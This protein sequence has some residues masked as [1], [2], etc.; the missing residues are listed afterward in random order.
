MDAP[1]RPDEQVAAER[2]ARRATWRRRLLLWVLPLVVAALAVYFYGTA[3]RFV[4]T[5]NAYVQQDRVDV[6]PQVP[7]DVDRVL[8]GENTRVS[9]GQ[10]V[11]GL[12]DTLFR[13]AAAGAESRLAATRTEVAALQAAYREKAGE[14]ELAR[15][16]AE[17]A[18]RDFARQQQLADRKLVPASQLDTSHRSAE[19]AT[20]A[21]DVLRL[22][23]AQAAA[24]LGGDPSQPLDRYPSVRAAIAELDRARVDLEHT[25]IRA[26]QAGIVSH[27][28][29]VGNRLEM[30]RAAF[31]IVTDRHVWVEANFKETDLEWVRP[32]Q[33]VR[34]D[35]DTYAQHRWTGRVESIAQAT[36]AAFSLLP[37]QNAAGNWV[38]VVQRIPVR[39][40]LEPLAGDPPLRDGMSSTV[41]IDTGPHTRFDRWFGRGR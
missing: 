16:T 36:G 35:V 18:V 27:L 24:R 7:G 12:D 23:L 9:A 40:A 25:V 26:P 28:P 15:G 4:A 33:N 17:F 19:L 1:L 32:G 41:E 5:D 8:V 30:G 20:G 37:P 6:A 14:V 10:P 39:I 13:I 3:G 31:A 29:K 21:I 34:V 11:I 38:K 2:T 22:Q